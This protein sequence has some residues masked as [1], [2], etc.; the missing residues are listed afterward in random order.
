[1]KNA[2]FHIAAEKLHC[3]IVPIRVHL[4]LSLSVENVRNFFIAS[5]KLFNLSTE[6]ENNFF[7]LNIF[8]TW[9]QMG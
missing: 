7:C 2:F 9:A 4:F 6:N 8:D 1:M 3:P 5:L